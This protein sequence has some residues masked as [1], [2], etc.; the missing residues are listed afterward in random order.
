MCY[1]KQYNPIL[2]MWM[3]VDEQNINQYSPVAIVCERPK[4]ASAKP[5]E[6]QVFVDLDT[7]KELAFCIQD[8]QPTDCTDCRELHLR[9]RDILDNLHSSLNRAVCRI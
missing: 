3:V 7:G 9:V 2:K 5:V 6:K 8:N 1:I 4:T